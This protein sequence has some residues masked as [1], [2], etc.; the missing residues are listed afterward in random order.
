MKTLMKI[1]IWVFVTVFMFIFIGNCLSFPN[2]F[3]NVIGGSLLLLYI[4][5]TIQTRF[6]TS[7]KFNKKT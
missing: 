7:I 5:I 6:F 3:T 2:V 4:V 1:F